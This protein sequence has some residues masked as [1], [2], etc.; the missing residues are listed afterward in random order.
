MLSTMGRLQVPVRPA[1]PGAPR[2]DWAIPAVI[3][4]AGWARPEQQHAP[5]TLT[6]NLDAN[7]PCRVFGG[8]KSWS[9][10]WSRPELRSRLSTSVRGRTSRHQLR[11]QR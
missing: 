1:F 10:G 4:V 7:L 9:I 5:T 3:I 2:S 6:H 8:H 11:A